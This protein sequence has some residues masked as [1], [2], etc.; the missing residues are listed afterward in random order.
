MLLLVCGTYA[1]LNIPKEAEPD[2]QVPVVY[3]S[4]SHEGISPE[5]SEIQLIRPMEQKLRSIEGVK[6]MRSRAY[7]GGGSVTLDFYSDK[8]I[9]DAL[10]DVREKVDI[11]KTDLPK[12][13][14]EPQVFEVNVGLFPVLAITLS[15]DIPERQLRHVAHELKDAIEGIASVLEVA[16]LGER[17]EQVEIIIDPMKIESYGTRPYPIP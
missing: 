13:T 5:D 1:Y 17:D 11:A 3:I 12:E 10:N 15:G 14:D 6:E 4:L 8:N 16:I 9:D 2:V 7:Q